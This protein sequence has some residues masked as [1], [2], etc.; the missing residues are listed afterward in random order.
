MDFRH[1][2]AFITVAE[3]LSITKAAGKLHISQPP[4]TRHIHQ[5]EQ[6]LGVALFVRHHHGVSLTEAGRVLLDKAR[7][8]DALAADFRDA[9]RRAAAADTS[10]IHVGIG[11]GLWNVVNRVRMDFAEHYPNVT[12]AAR[13][14][15][16]WHSVGDMLKN[17]ALD[18]VVSRPPFD[19][20]IAD[21]FRIYEERIQ[22]IVSDA[23]PLAAQTSVGLRDLADVPLLLWDREIA[24]ILYDKIIEMYARENPDTPMVPTPGAGPFNPEGL[25]LVASGKGVYLGYGVPVTAP[26]APTGVAVRPLNHPEATL[27]VCA[28]VRKD[29]RSPVVKQFLESVWR[30]YPPRRPSSPAEVP[31]VS[32]VRRA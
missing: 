1:I 30:A 23:S 22:V 13:D 2:R 31:V 7:A 17:H 26:H 12:I 24:P 3:T 16:C 18:V 32:V 11:W 4:L 8:L 10:T 6:E 9:A 15:S 20:A 5:L 25:M 21:V 29:E 27:D 28:V 14:A 19:T